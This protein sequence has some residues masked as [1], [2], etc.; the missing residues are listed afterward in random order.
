MSKDEISDSVAKS[1]YSKASP[2]A[3]Y[4]TDVTVKQ[5]QLEK[6]LMENTLKNHSMGRMLGAPEVLQMGK[7]FIRFIKAKKCLDIGTFT[8]AS[9]VAWS[10]ALPDDGIVYT[11]DINHEPFNSIGKPLIEKEE[12]IYKKISLIAGQA[13]ESLDKLIS[14][15]ESGKW[16]FAFIDADKTSYP[17]YYDRVMKLLRPGGV[18]LIDNALMGG[19]VADPECSNEGQIAVRKLNAIISEDDRCDNMLLNV[20]DGTHVVFKH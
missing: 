4:C 9:A 6:N 13:L 19:G 2:V 8:G 7:N 14:N 1:Y 18:I 16:D 10:S 20:G 3:K 11:F 15:G 12:N 17:N 5:S